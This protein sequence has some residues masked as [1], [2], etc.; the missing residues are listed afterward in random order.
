MSELKDIWNSGDGKLPEDKLIAYL[1][2]RLPAEEGMEADALEGL[3]GLPAAEAKQ[4][5]AKANYDLHKT[6]SARKR[7][8]KRAIKDNPWAW[9]AIVVI[10]LLCVVAY[11]VLQMSTPK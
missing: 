1:E 2:G 5:V 3:Q 6:L 8:R 4:M 7:Q 11:V 9:L 10:L